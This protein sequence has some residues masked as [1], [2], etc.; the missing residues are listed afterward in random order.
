MFIR[1]E[2][3]PLTFDIQSVA[4][5]TFETNFQNIFWQETIYVELLKDSAALIL[6]SNYS[7]IMHTWTS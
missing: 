1:A 6:S 5:L 4:F 2:N 3:N 7:D